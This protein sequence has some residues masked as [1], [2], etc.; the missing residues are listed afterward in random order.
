MTRKLTCYGKY[1][2]TNFLTVCLLLL[3]VLLLN[4]YINDLFISIPRPI[5]PSL[6]SVNKELNHLENDTLEQTLFQKYA[7]IS[8]NVDADPGYFYHLPIVALTWRRVFFEPLFILVHSDRSKSTQAANLTISYLNQLNVKVFHFKAEAN[9]E[10]MSA[11]V[12]REMSGLLP[13]LLV[14]ENDFILTS[15]SDLYPLN[16]KHYGFANDNS[17]KLWNA[18]CS[19]AFK[20]AGQEYVMYQMGWWKKMKPHFI[21]FDLKLKTNVIK[22]TYRNEK[23]SMA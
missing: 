17:I 12:V 14:K 6:H 16:P 23:V 18:D 22:R 10:L 20:L 5:V 2:K 3:L 8:V 9:Y 7:I 11:M 4:T 15:D 13:D 19:G 21:R 1:S